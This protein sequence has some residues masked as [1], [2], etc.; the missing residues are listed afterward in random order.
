MNFGNLTPR[1]FGDNLFGPDDER[2]EICIHCGKRW[3]SLHYKDGVCHECRQKGLPG[4][5][6][7]AKKQNVFNYVF[8]SI[9]IFIF[10]VL[11]VLLIYQAIKQG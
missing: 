3:Y 2:K 4:R 1:Q 8:G 10:A 7:I 9:G 5:T 6:E 11:T